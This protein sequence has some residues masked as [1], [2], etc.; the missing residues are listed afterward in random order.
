MTQSFSDGNKETATDV[1]AKVT[2]DGSI[3]VGDKVFTPEALAKKLQHQ[4][5][6][7][8]NL[9]TE[10]TNHVENS[11]KL[12]D[13]LDQI[14]KKVT[15]KDDLTSLLETMKQNNTDNQE[16]P[17]TETEDTQPLSKDELVTAA[18]NQ[19]NAQ[20][21]E[22]AQ[23]DNL[24]KA[25]AAAKENYGDDFSTKIDSIG[26]SLGMNVQQV[27]KMAKEQPSAWAKLFIPVKNERGSP[28]PTK[29]SSLAGGTP[30][31]A[32]EKRGGYVAMR[33]NKDQ[34]AE[35]KRRMDA[36]LNTQQ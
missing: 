9:E 13:R 11:S 15:D 6:H 17:E 36:A 1:T 16:P 8:A 14:E 27:V 35:F 32:T 4:D 18:V 19:L 23:E 10:N 33:S 29:T 26:E 22:K 31:P 12:L 3:I 34:R 25:I 28:D 24:N 21:E 30:P 2:E 7:I 5:A 20:S